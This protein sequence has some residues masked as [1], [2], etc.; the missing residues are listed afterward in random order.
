M[1]VSAFFRSQLRSTPRV[2]ERVSTDML[3]KISL[4]S[5]GYVLLVG[6]V[7]GPGHSALHYLDE[8]AKGVQDRPCS[9]WGEELP[10]LRSLRA[11]QL[12]CP[13]LG[14]RFEE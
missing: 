5:P 12:G 9:G 10:F 11:V 2:A 13:Q 7:Q 8:G 4:Q 6:G 14:N 1:A 3:Y